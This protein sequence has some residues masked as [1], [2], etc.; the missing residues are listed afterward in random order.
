MRKFS[1]AFHGPRQSAQVTST[2]GLSRKYLQSGRKA[3]H[4]AV[5][6]KGWQLQANPL[7]R[8]LLAPCLN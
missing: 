6:D 8:S 1:K 7:L 4:D 5:N 3:C 2:L